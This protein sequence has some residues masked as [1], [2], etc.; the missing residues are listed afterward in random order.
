MT[1][2]AFNEEVERCYAAGMDEF[3]PKPV[4][5]EDLFA[6]LRKLAKQVKLNPMRAQN[7]R[8]TMRCW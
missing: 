1:A 8:R 7:H 5:M 2:G 4:V 3:L 6:V